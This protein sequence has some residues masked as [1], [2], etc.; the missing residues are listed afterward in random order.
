MQKFDLKLALFALLLF[1]AVLADFASSLLSLLTDAAFVG[2][3]IAVIWPKLVGKSNSKGE[4][5]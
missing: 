2:A 5:H 1:G 4:G 3:A